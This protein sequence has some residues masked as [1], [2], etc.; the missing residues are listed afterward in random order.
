MKTSFQDLG[1]RILSLKDHQKLLLAIN[2]INNYKESKKMVKK[3]RKLFEVPAQPNLSDPTEF[4][5][6]IN[7]LK[8]PLDVNSKR[9]T[10]TDFY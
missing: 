6:R 5:D 2:D 10:L 3:N 1:G 8:K 7:I 9:M 4:F